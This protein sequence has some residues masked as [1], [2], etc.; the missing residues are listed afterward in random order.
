MSEILM[1]QTV[2]ADVS[3]KPSAVAYMSFYAPVLVLASMKT[4]SDRSSGPI[5]V[6]ST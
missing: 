3:S 2:K 4:R 1:K 5:Y 6:I